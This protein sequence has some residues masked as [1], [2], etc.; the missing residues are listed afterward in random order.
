ML[1]QKLNEIRTA[2]GDE[3]RQQLSV[4]QEHAE[5]FAHKAVD[6]MVERGDAFELSDDE[7]RML[8]S[9]RQFCNRNASGVFKWQKPADEGI[10]IPKKHSFISDPRD[11]SEQVKVLRCAANV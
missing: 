8:E 10:V 5:H 6:D 2:V 1:Y 3:I 11:K 7:I 9:Y 4:M